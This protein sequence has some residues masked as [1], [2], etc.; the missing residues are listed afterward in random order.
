M[1]AEGPG[2]ARPTKEEKTQLSRLAAENKQLKL[3]ISELKKSNQ[4]LLAQLNALSGKDGEPTPG[5]SQPSQVVEEK[6]ANPESSEGSATG[7][8]EEKDVPEE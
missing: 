8:K 1:S 7:E 2:G 3:E 6:E 4:E 5:T